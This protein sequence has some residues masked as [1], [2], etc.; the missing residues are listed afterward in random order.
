[1]AIKK[2]PISEIIGSL[3]RTRLE[4][5]YERE[6]LLTSIKKSGVQNPV[7]VKKV[8]GGY[9][10]FAGDRRLDCARELKHETIPAEVHEGTSDRDAVM[11][12]FVDNINRKDYTPLEEAYAYVKLHKDYGWSVEEIRD[13]C[14][15]HETRIYA[16]MT[17]KENLPKKMEKAIL[18]GKISVG[19]AMLLLR[20]EDKKLMWKLFEETLEGEHSVRDLEYIL[21]RQKPDKEKNEKE[22]ILDVAEDV[23]DEDK[24]VRKLRDE[25]LVK[26]Y[27][28][29]RG[30][31]T[32]LDS[33][34]PTE[35]MEMLETLLAALKK[36]L[37]RVRKIVNQNSSREEF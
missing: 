6:E 9:K 2:I 20:F 34:G 13:Y 22:K 35:M 32:I 21:K 16:L 14:G 12:G 28:S 37:P 30:L 7:K 18:D 24:K 36:S 29:R 17:F 4:Y 27:R 31:K 33:N 19:H 26:I 10:V 11:M 23:F 8:K 3:C 25:E 1:M 5:D 15:K